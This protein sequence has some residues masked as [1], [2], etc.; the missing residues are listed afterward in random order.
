MASRKPRETRHAAHVLA[1]AVGPA[2]D[3]QAEDSGVWEESGGEM[4]RWAMYVAFLAVTT[5]V[6][7]AWVMR[8]SVVAAQLSLSINVPKELNDLLLR[9]QSA[10]GASG[11]GHA[12]PGSYYVDDYLA[13]FGGDACAAVSFIAAHGGKI[14]RF[15]E[16]AYFCGVHVVVH[17][18]SNVGFGHSTLVVGAGGSYFKEKQ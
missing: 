6:W 7:G 4:K 15:G 5:A 1:D 3:Q 12:E 13:Y 18:P 8:V 2:K 17:A 16:G 14:I 11:T 9:R 10:M